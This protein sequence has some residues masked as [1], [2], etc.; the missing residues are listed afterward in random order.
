MQM[1]RNLLNN[2]INVHGGLAMIKVIIDII[3]EES[4]DKREKYT[5]PRAGFE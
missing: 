1:S 5:D 4:L 2:I 3:G